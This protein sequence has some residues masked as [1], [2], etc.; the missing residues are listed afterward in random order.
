MTAVPEPGFFFVQCYISY[1]LHCVG[2]SSRG[3]GFDSY[4]RQFAVDGFPDGRMKDDERFGRLWPLGR[5]FSRFFS[6]DVGT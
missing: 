1:N 4:G 3:S 6:V 5:A 2:R